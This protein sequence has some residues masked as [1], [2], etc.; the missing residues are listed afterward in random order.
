MNIQLSDKW[1]IES[2]NY[3]WVLT[4]YEQRQRK[5]RK[6]EVK[7]DYLF[8]DKWYFPTIRQCL[9]K[10]IDEECKDSKTLND[11]YEKLDRIYAKVEE[12]KNDLFTIATS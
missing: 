8:E 1:K 12:I 9:R 4:F 6:T 3:S 5:N 7:E 10:Y 11:L 2:D